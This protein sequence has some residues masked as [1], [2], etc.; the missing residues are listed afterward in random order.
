MK[1]NTSDIKDQLHKLISETEDEAILL[2]IQDYFTMLRSEE[3]DWWDKISEVEKS[4]I[5]R[6]IEQLDS[7]MGISHDEVKKKVNKILGR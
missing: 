4:H 7:G 6:G 2:M 3:Y 5:Q 1:T